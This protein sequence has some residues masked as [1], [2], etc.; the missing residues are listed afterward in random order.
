MGRIVVTEFVSLDGV[1]ED[2][3]GSEDFEHGGWSF[4]ISR[5]DEGDRF[6]LDEAME[7]SRRGLAIESEVYGPVSPENQKRLRE[8]EAA[9]QQANALYRQ[10]KLDEAI[11]API[12]DQEDTTMILTVTIQPNK[13]GELRRQLTVRTNLDKESATISISGDVAP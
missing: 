8:S 12:P 6:K 5:G 13:A 1:I 3:G 7:A 9:L 4:E 10:G 2:P 11:K